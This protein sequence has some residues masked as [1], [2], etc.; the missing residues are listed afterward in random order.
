MVHWALCVLQSLVSLAS[1]SFRI[2]TVFCSVLFLFTYLTFQN[3]KHCKKGSPPPTP[4]E[5]GLSLP[6]ELLDALS[7]DACAPW[8]LPV[9]V[10]FKFDQK[11]W[12]GDSSEGYRI[13]GWPSQLVQ[14]VKSHLLLTLTNQGLKGKSRELTPAGWPQISHSNV[15]Q[16]L[17]PHF[18][19]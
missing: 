18:P 1:L 3:I 12:H 15:L 19:K 7:G 8:L 9:L 16:E 4:P 10:H 5:P 2:I 17:P 6:W 14:Q 11:W 13:V